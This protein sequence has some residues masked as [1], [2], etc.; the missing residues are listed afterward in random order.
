MKD[1]MTGFKDLVYLDAGLTRYNSTFYLDIV[2]PVIFDI[3]H[4]IEEVE[5][6]ENY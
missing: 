2:R 5:D 4:M 6:P 3:Y 1:I